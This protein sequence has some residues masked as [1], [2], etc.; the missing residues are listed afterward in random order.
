MS[1]MVFQL[2]VLE[3]ADLETF[4]TGQLNALI[5]HAVGQWQRVEYANNSA[6]AGLYK[7]G[8]RWKF[9]AFEAIKVYN[10]RVDR[11]KTITIS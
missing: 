8:L 9:L 4:S 6:N 10:Q 2:D 11:H 7:R 1:D 3:D 5:K